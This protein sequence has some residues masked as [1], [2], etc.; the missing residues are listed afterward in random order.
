[1]KSSHYDL[2]IFDWDGTLSDS[3]GW[4]VTCLRHAAEAS[5]LAIPSETLAR[6]VIGLSLQEAMDTI[7]PGIDAE[8]QRELMQHYRSYYHSQPLESLSLFEGVREMLEGCLDLGYQLAVATGKARSGL[9]PALK[10][11]KTESLFHA[12]RCADETASKPHPRMVLEL[13]DELKVRPERALI[14]GDSPYDLQM[15]A[16][17]GVDGVA[18]ACGSHTHEFLMELEPLAC[19]E[20][21]R[22]LSRFL[23][24]FKGTLK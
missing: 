21:T 1:M 12:T 14:I 23:I 11:S 22:D 19:L 9:A 2:L 15:A 24:D 17:A 4:I 7:F 13:L 8:T 6:S 3:I 5:G 16:N 10:A 20:Q 18:V